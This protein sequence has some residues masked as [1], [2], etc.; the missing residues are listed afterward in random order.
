MPTAPEP[1]QRSRNRAP[2]TRGARILKSVSRR[3]SEVGRVSN[4]G[5]LFSLRP[6]YFP[7]MIRMKAIHRFRSLLRPTLRGLGVHSSLR[8]LDGSLPNRRQPHPR[9]ALHA[10]DHFQ[11]FSRSLALIDVELCFLA[12]ILQNIQIAD[13][14]CDPKFGQ[15]GLTRAHHL[16]GPANL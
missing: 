11:G 12:R 2:L 9:V 5:G 4:D 16:A 7:A 14:I 6:R 1:A 13:Q 3:R 8:N 15:A 10:L